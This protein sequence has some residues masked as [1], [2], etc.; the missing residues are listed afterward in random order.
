[1]ES[2]Q[3]FIQT[4][5]GYCMF[6]ITCAKNLHCSSKRYKGRCLSPK[7][8]LKVNFDLNY[9]YINDFR[10]Q[11]LKNSK[12]THPNSKFKYGVLKF[13]FWI[14]IQFYTFL[15]VLTTKKITIHLGLSNQMK[16]ITK[17]T[18]M[19]IIVDNV[20]KCI[21]KVCLFLALYIL[22]KT[23]KSSRLLCILALHVPSF[24]GKSCHFTLS[25]TPLPLHPSLRVRECVQKG[26][27]LE[28]K[29]LTNDFCHHLPVSVVTS[30]IA[31]VFLP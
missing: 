10:I 24:I 13:K 14:T 26:S 28:L 20:N 21:P 7:T 5:Y 3:S 29:W 23:W 15:L 11:R 31:V 22:H 12:A 9:V 19:S 6:M 27:N 17:C 1:M 18:I 25:H 30:Y 4:R 2:Q 8:F 16:Q